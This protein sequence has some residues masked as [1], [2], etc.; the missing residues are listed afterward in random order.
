MAVLFK[1]YA[2]GVNQLSETYGEK[3]KKKN[4][5]EKATEPTYRV[6]YRN[7]LAAHTVTENLIK[8]YAVE[9]ATCVLSEQLKRNLKQFSD[10][11]KQLNIAFKICRQI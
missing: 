5:N 1:G 9:M 4:D 8:I 2:W 3:L 10:L 6:G 11:I 7:A